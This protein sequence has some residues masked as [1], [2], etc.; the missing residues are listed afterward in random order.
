MSDKIE[1]II[2]EEPFPW[3]AGTFVIGKSTSGYTLQYSGNYNPITGAGDWD[4]MDESWPA[5]KQCVVECH[6]ECM[7]FRLSGNS[8]NVQL[9][10]KQLNVIA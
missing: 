3:K 10:W 1:I 5:D 8:G 2:G 6:A 4:S 7:Y 9:H